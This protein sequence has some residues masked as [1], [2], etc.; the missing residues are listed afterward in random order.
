LALLL[1]ALVAVK[2]TRGLA[3]PDPADRRATERFPI[4]A[5]STCSFASQV[6]ENIG[7]VRI[8]D[9]S[10]DGIGLLMSRK[11]DVGVLLAITLSNPARNLTKTVLMQVMHVTPQVGTYLVGGKFTAPLTYQELTTLVM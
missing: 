2:H 10:M 3:M 9:I 7:S 6:V 5:D 8:K 1:N 4:N 11:L